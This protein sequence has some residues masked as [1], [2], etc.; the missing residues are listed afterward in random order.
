MFLIYVISVIVWLV[1]LTTLALSPKI[2]YVTDRV[3]NLLIVVSLIPLINT[4]YLISAFIGAVFNKR[5]E[6]ERTEAFKEACE[7]LDT[8]LDI[9]INKFKK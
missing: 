5:T 7:K 6:E 3:F 1:L 9:T 8:L 4:L 2:Q